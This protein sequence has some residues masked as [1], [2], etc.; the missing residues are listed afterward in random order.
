[1]GHGGRFFRVTTSTSQAS[2]SAHPPAARSGDR[3]HAQTASV[4]VLLRPRA[5]AHRQ[6]RSGSCRRSRSTHLP[7]PA[8]D[9]R[10]R[11]TSSAVYLGL[12]LKLRVGYTLKSVCLTTCHITQTIQTIHASDF[13]F[14]YLL[15]FDRWRI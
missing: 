11:H 7:M 6:D 10:Q 2:V 1:M 3:P 14:S 9:I 8:A 13:I 12:T 15:I 4:H 5:A